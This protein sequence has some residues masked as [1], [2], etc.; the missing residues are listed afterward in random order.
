MAACWEEHCLRCN[1]RS[2]ARQLLLLLPP[3]NNPSSALLIISIEKAICRCCTGEVVLDQPLQ[4]GTGRPAQRQYQHHH[5]LVSPRLDTVS[6]SVCPTV[7]F[8]S[9]CLSILCYCC[10]SCILPAHSATYVNAEFS[11]SN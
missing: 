4:L 10:M 8:G 6:Q 1:R 7:N 11:Y 9:L 5:Q 3:S 2:G